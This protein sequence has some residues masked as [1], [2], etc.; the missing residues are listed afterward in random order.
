MMFNHLLPGY[1]HVTPGQLPPISRFT[2]IIGSHIQALGWL[3][4]HLITCMC[5]KSPHLPLPVIPGTAVTAGPGPAE[6]LCDVPRRRRGH[7]SL[8]SVKSEW[9][10]TCH[11]CAASNRGKAGGADMCSF[12]FFGGVLVTIGLL[13][14]SRMI[15]Y[16]KIKLHLLPPKT[17]ISE[18]F[19]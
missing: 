2:A 10:V 13:K 7:H 17:F 1:R 15:K 3:Y 11:S 14:T 4:S 19:E 5:W 9:Y 8:L 18:Q 16:P 6:R 12:S